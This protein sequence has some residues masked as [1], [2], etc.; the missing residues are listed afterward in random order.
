MLQ[1]LQRVSGCLDG[2]AGLG[3]GVEAGHWGVRSACSRV[4]VVP[5]ASEVDAFFVET[6]V[7]AQV[8]EVPVDE[9]AC[10]RQQL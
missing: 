1:R 6:E 9:V 10:R 4:I 8:S 7:A 3:S 2:T 5:G